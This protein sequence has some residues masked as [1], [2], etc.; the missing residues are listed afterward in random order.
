MTQEEEIKKLRSALKQAQA[1]IDA[2]YATIARTEAMVVN[3]VCS[4]IEIDNLKDTLNRADDALRI[5]FEIL[6][7]Y[8]CPTGVEW[9]TT[10]WLMV[11]TMEEISN[12]KKSQQENPSDD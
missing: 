6:Y 1:V 10:A 5:C 11:K 4:K 12:I 3:S 2:Q 7:P 9:G 8:G